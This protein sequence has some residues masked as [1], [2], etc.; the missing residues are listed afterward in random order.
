MRTRLFLVP[1]T[2]LAASCAGPSNREQ[3]LMEEIERKVLLPREASPLN[4]Y[5]RHYAFTGKGV[6]AVYVA[7]YPPSNQ[8]EMGFVTEDWGWRPLTEA[9]TREA[10]VSDAA[11]RLRLGEANSRRWHALDSE[12]PSADD[13][14]CDYVNIGYDPVTKQ[15]L[16]VECN[17]PDGRGRPD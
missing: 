12:F 5:A 4:R 11:W 8:G 9:E 2:I 1:F 10:E 7:I 14:G 17:G 16:Y 6:E 13:G 15:F 3:V